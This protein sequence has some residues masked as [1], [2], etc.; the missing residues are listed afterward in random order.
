MEGSVRL[1]YC[2][3][4]FI[5]LLCTSLVYGD[6]FLQDRY[7]NCGSY[8]KPQEVRITDVDKDFIYSQSNSYYSPER[9]C[10]MTIIGKKNHQIELQLTTLDIDGH[11]YRSDHCGGL[12]CKDYLKL[13]N[14][15]RVDNA[16]LIPGIGQWGLCGSD[17]PQRTVFKT[18]NNYVTIQFRADELSDYKRGFVLQFQQYP[19]KNP[20]I[21]PDGGFYGGWNDG[22]RNELQ[23]DWNEQ[24]QLPGD[25]QPD[26]NPDYE[27]TGGKQC[28][29][30]TGC[31]LYSF[32]PSKEKDVSKRSGCY[33]CSKSWRDDFASAQRICYTETQ[34]FNLLTTL[35]DSSVGDGKVR[36]YRGCKKFLDSLGRSLNFCFC[37]TDLCNSGRRVYTNIFLSVFCLFF[38][39][40]LKY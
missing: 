24:S 22:S 2:K 9:N 13:F 39:W 33:V 5:C 11:A 36:E 1:K 35:V 14:S 10:I 27:N 16:R 20:G 34:Y 23:V 26:K 8:E 12:C 28:Y 3:Q 18:T 40:F 29:E 4:L 19:W 31:S 6:R 25:F 30:C 21:Y 32:Y 38:F 15:Y 37:D 17:L 7:D